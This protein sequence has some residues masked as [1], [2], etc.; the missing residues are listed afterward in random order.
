MNLQKILINHKS[1][2]KSRFFAGTE[3]SAAADLFKIHFAL[4]RQLRQFDQVYLFDWGK[5]NFLFR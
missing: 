4:N 3:K 5:C 1:S 2:L